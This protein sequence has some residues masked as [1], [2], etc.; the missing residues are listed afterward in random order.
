MP[1]DLEDAE[2]EVHQATA[3]MSDERSHTVSTCTKDTSHCSTTEGCEV[4]FLTEP[5]SVEPV[6]VPQSLELIK[7]RG[8]EEK[9]AGST[10]LG[11]F[12]T[13]SH[14]HQTEHS[15][16]IMDLTTAR[17]GFEPWHAEKKTKKP[18]IEVLSSSD[19]PLPAQ[20]LLSEPTPVPLVE[21][22]KSKDQDIFSQELSLKSSGDLFGSDTDMLPAET[23]NVPLRSLIVELGDNVGS[24]MQQEKLPVKSKE[25]G[26][27]KPVCSIED[28][29]GVLPPDSIEMME[30]KDCATPTETSKQIKSVVMTG[31]STSSAIEQQE[32][33]ELL[34]EVGSGNECSST[35]DEPGIQLPDVQAVKD[36]SEVR[37]AE[38][39]LESLRSKPESQLTTEEK[40]WQLAAK[41]GSTLESDRVEL[42]HQTKERLHER[43]GNAGLLDKVSFPL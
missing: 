32:G 6:E 35:A 38:S 43:L 41:A 19:N 27:N 11:L 21:E 20:S 26:K 33:V 14:E 4:V 40:I 10:D 34:V 15:P 42:D 36:L 17:S 39:A 29:T 24:T 1:P 23:L 25:N 22:L 13:P 12:S 2:A 28:M 16:L 18:L 37:H 7:P 3:A 30:G 8:V 31:S 5:T 9:L